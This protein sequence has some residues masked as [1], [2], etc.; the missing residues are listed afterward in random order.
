[1]KQLSIIVRSIQ[2]HSYEIYV[3][4]DGIIQ[5]MVVVCVTTA[6]RGQAHTHRHARVRTPQHTGAG[7]RAQ[8]AKPH[9]VSAHG[10]TPIFLLLLSSNDTR[11][12]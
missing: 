4:F 5:T 3:T 10:P 11:N 12:L 2:F 9:W 6:G 8:L 7:K 1:M